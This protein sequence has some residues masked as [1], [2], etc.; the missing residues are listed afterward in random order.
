MKI[1]HR[2]TRPGHYQVYFSQNGKQIFLQKDSLGEPLRDMDQVK[3]V[4]GHLK[5]NGYDP[6]DWNWW[7]KDKSY[8][9]ENAINNWVKLSDCSPEWKEKRKRIAE[10]IFIPHFGKMD[11]REVTDVRIAEFNANLKDKVNLKGK[12][13]S[14]K[15]RK[16]L[17]GELKCFFNS[18]R[19]SLK[20]MPTFPR[21]KAQEPIIRWI[22][23]K[24]QDETFEFIPPHHKPIFTFMRFT[25]CRP[26]EAGGLLKKNLF[27]E[28]RQFVL[29]TVL[30]K[31]KV[32][33]ENTKTKVVKPLPIIPEI[34]E[35][36]RSGDKTDSPFVF[37]IEGRPYTIRR[38]EK[39]W[40]RTN[41]L[42]H[43]K[44]GTTPIN[45][46]NGLKHSFGCQRLED[47]YSLDEVREVMG[48]STIEMTRR[49]ARYRTEKLVNVMRGKRGLVHT[50]FIE[51]VEAKLLK[52]Q[53]KWSGR[54]DLNLRHL[55]PHA[56]A[57]PGC[58]T[59]RKIPW[60]DGVME[61]WNTGSCKEKMLF[62]ISP[63]HHS[64]I[65]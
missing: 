6:S 8:L 22:D 45:L 17:M 16:I 44:Y 24:G 10:N 31:G 46:Y 2:Q 51:S 15:Y 60:N 35:A 11:V 20:E 62:S 58:A 7:K 1:H 57:L 5:G 52:L 18:I 63:T 55:T 30:G 28:H 34:E 47:G 27:W 42:A 49:Y 32:V 36:L 39:I 4:V 23:E 3:A 9:F 59:P 25:A 50:P 21:V 33:K 64:N 41:E 61:H 65:P 14:D 40:N 29:A 26:N 38:L 53:G 19:K 43:Q 54:E 13:N 56:S 48:H 12:K 37:A